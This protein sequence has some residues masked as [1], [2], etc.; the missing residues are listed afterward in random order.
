[1]NKYLPVIEF[2]QY[3]K[4]TGGADIDMIYFLQHYEEQWDF[5]GGWKAKHEI[6][7]CRYGTGIQRQIVLVF[8]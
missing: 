7:K 2:S 8:V 5:Q 4:E 6:E 3:M 1:M